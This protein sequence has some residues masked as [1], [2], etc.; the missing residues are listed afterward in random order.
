MPGTE[1]ARHTLVT[2]PASFPL[3]GSMLQLADPEEQTLRQ[4]I[5]GRIKGCLTHS[6]CSSE[7]KQTNKK[8]SESLWEGGT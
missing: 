4:G 6:R 7:L 8:I 5:R 1:E 3:S 2:C